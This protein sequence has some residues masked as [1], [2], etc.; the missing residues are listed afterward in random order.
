MSRRRSA[1]WAA[2][3]A[4][5]MLVVPAGAQAGDEPPL[6]DEGVAKYMGIARA[7]W[8]G[9]APVCVRDGTTLI[10][11]QAF[12]FDDP[13][14]EVAAR[15]EQ[16]GCQLWIDRGTWPTLTRVERCTVVV[17]EWGH[18]LGF[19]HS[20]DPG[21]VMAEYPRRPPGG[22][23]SIA[24]RRRQRAARAARTARRCAARARAAAARAGRARSRHRRFRGRIACFRRA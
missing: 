18:M 14:P 7:F 20:A 10:P 8:N 3:L 12:L 17:H 15:A 19:G 22:C 4:A 9:A 2:A 21:S 13:D 5:A 16:P 23:A 24:A 6:L 11:V 1:L